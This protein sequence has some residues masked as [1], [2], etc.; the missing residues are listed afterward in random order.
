[1]FYG[2]I[3]Y[4]ASLKTH[5]VNVISATHANYPRKCRNAK[6]TA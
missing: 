3:I 1:M 4:S 2:R 5:K 6:I